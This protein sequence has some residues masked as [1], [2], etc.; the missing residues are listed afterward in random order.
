VAGIQIEEMGGAMRNII[1]KRLSVAGV[2][3]AATL[4]LVGVV[5]GPAVS[6]SASP[7]ALTL[8]SVGGYASYVEIPFGFRRDRGTVVVPD[9]SCEIVGYGGGDQ[10]L[11]VEVYD[12][13]TGQHIGTTFYNGSFGETIVTFEGPN[14]DSF[15][16]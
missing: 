1:P 5:A 15:P 6:A 8:C 7:E 10:D 4:A 2:I 13:D 11:Q 16:G 12:A 14:M 3:G 9:G